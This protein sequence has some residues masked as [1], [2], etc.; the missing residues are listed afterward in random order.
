VLLGS[1]RGQVEGFSPYDAAHLK[2]LT[3]VGAHVSTAPVV[4]TADDP[5]TEPANR[6]VILALMQ[7]K[8][9]DVEPLLSHT[10]IPAQAGEAFA[11]LASAP[12]KY[13]GIAIDWTRA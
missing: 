10:I 8:R 13:L 6:R 3:I 4:S 7:Q 12:E 11:A 1:T 9:L 2:G 5:W